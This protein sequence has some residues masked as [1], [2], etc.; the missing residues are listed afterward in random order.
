M[1][2]SRAASRAMSRAVSRPGPAPGRVVT[3][4]GLRAAL[5]LALAIGTVA[6]VAGT[7]AAATQR[8]VTARGLRPHT[9]GRHPHAPQAVLGTSAAPAAPAQS[10]VAQPSVLPPPGEATVPGCLAA[11]A[12][13]AAYAAPGFTSSCPGNA[14]GHQATTLCVG[15]IAPCNVERL[16]VIADPCP[17][18]YMNEASNSWALLGA[19]VPV[20]PYGACS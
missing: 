15:T 17:A 4:R 3:R 6:A 19:D 8:H 10:F 14:D 12:Y 13:L 9:R 20:D 16:I 2:R 11:L 7:S 1:W 18:A 5:T